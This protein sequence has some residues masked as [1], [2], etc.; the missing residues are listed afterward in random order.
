M[1]A[2]QIAPSSNCHFVMGKKIWVVNCFIY[3]SNLQHKVGA[4]NLKISAQREQIA[5]S[6][7]C[8]PKINASVITLPAENST[9]HLAQL[10]RPLF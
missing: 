10:Q 1:P 7:S 6:C 4:C 5:L 2:A 8:H 9:L 3:F